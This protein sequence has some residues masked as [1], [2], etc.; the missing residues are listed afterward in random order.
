MATGPV[1]FPWVRAPIPFIGYRTGWVS[2]GSGSNSPYWLPGWLDFL[3]FELQFPLLATG[4]ADS[5]SVQA[6]IPP[7][8]YRTGGFSLGSGSNT[9]YWLPYWRILLRFG[10]Q[11]PFLVTG[12]AVFPRVQAPIPFSRYRQK[13]PQ[14]RSVVYSK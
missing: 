13:I 9:L 6:P 1:D 11:Y 5:P 7:I 10:L 14:K 2:L 8:G 3:G 12:P 4:L